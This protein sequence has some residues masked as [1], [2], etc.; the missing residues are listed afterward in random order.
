[1]HV[2]RCSRHSNMGNHLVNKVH[3]NEKECPSCNTDS[4]TSPCCSWDTQEEQHHMAEL[5]ILQSGI[6]VCNYMCFFGSQVQPR[7]P[8]THSYMYLW[9]GCSAPG[10]NMDTRRSFFGQSLKKGW[11]ILNIKF[12]LKI[13]K[14]GLKV[15]SIPTLGHI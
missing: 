11:S 6:F 10:Q 1:M 4:K 13:S 14:R 8:N 2:S 9:W 12:L 15:S 5:I 7:G 3:K